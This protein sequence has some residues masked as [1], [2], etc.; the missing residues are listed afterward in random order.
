MMF[1]A[2]SIDEIN[3]TMIH[4]SV[5]EGEALMAN[6]EHAST[7][8]LEHASISYLL[9]HDGDSNSSHQACSQD[10]QKGGGGEFNFRLRP[11]LFTQKPQ[12]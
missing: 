10:F 8:Y 6:K 7:F 4:I 2:S 12:N 3:F 9:V 5:Y 1:R 11:L